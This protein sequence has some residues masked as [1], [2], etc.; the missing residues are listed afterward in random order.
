MTPPVPANKTTIEFADGIP[1]TRVIYYSDILVEADYGS[2]E[3][4]G[5]VD[6][7][8]IHMFECDSYEYPVNAVVCQYNL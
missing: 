5:Y 4:C 3:M 6:I 7:K 1:P 2:V 8:T